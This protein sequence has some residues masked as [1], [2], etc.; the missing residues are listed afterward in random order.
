M[1]L[2]TDLR[3]VAL[4]L[5]TDFGAQVTFVREV[6]GTYNPE[7]GDTGT[8]TE[9]SYTAY[10]YADEY[11]KYAIQNSD[12]RN[13]DIRMY[14]HNTSTVPLVG[15]K[16]TYNSIDYEVYNIDIFNVAGNT[17]LYELQLRV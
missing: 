4:Q 9:T 12:V 16:I 2:T 8:T 15:D 6:E 5:L 14:V 3:A 11:S 1:S 17:V 10:G 13:T 7:T